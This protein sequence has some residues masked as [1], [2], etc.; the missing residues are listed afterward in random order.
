MHLTLESSDWILVTHW[1]LPSH[2]PFQVAGEELKLSHF[3]L[4]LE[5]FREQWVFPVQEKG[6]FLLF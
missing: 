6:M 1:N 3:T 5:E 4:T 2:A